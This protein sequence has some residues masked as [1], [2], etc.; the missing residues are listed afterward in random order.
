MRKRA[1]IV[2]V[3]RGFFPS[4]AR[5]QAAIAAGLVSVGGVALTKASAESGRRRADRGRAAPPLCLARRGQARRG[6]RRF[7][8]RSRG[9][10]LPRCRRLDRRL[11]RRSARAGRGE[12]SSPS[13]SATDSS[14][15]RLAADPR[16]RSLEGLDARALDARASRRAAGGDRLRRELHLA[17][18]RAAACPETRRRARRGSSASSSRSSRSGRPT[19]SRAG[20]GARRRS[21]APATPFAPASQRRAGRRSA[22]LP[23]PILGGGG[24]KEFLIA[25]RHG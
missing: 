8:A 3:E 5:A 6:A 24:A 23:S 12:R 16:V 14:I 2:L 13:M 22:S 20:S 21:R 25:A 18:A 7:R 19:S 9:P 10:R 4:R 17:T 1:D 11:H 15:P